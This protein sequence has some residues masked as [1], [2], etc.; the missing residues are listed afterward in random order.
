DHRTFAG[1]AFLSLLAAGLFGLAPSI[2]AGARATTVL[3]AVSSTTEDRIWRRFRSALVILEIAMAVAILVGATTIVRT[4]GEL[5][6]TDLGARNERALVMEVML[7]RTTYAS[8]DRILRFYEQL[9]G[10]L[11]TVP[12]IE[13][14]GST[15]L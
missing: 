11:R 9:R 5:M 2:S 3:R 1:L 12:G 6:A 8:S 14:V 7:P 10:E 4:V 15:N 13:E